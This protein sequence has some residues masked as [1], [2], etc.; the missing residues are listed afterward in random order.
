[1][2]GWQLLGD[3]SGNQG[4]INTKVEG[5]F[6]KNLDASFEPKCDLKLPD[7]AKKCLLIRFC[8]VCRGWRTATLNGVSTAQTGSICRAGTIV[9]ARP[10]FMQ[11]VKDGF[12]RMF[13]TCR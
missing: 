6:R 2:R 8:S 9:L 10:R 1:M 13:N 7:S 3:G 12:E 5:G 11:F 4:A